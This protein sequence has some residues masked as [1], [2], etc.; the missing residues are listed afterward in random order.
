MK[1]TFARFHAFVACSAIFLATAFAN[2]V[3][4]TEYQIDPVHSSVMFMIKHLVVSNTK[5]KFKDVKGNFSYVEGK[6]TEWK[7]DAAIQV[8]SIDTGDLKR[9]NHLKSPDF[10]DAKKYPTIHFKS[11]RIE[12]LQG[13]K[14]KLIGDLTMHGVTK[15]VALDLMINGLV[16]DPWGNKKAGFSASGNLSRKDFEM[17]WNKALDKGGLM[18][19]NDVKIEIEVEGNANKS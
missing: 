8:N 12:G 19:G 16:T 4:A 13:D 2:F 14:A 6:P 1:K 17:N 5:G 15:E 18:I 3:K 11:K 7:T 10:F 9:D